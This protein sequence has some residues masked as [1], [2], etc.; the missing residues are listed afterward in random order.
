MTSVRGFGRRV[1]AFGIIAGSV[2]LRLR[3][4]AVAELLELRNRAQNGARSRLRSAVAFDAQIWVNHPVS[5][6]HKPR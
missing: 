1:R 4:A 6:G 5:Q 3:S 2:Q